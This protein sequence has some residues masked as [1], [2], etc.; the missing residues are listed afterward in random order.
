MNYESC[1]RI[2][3]RVRPEVTFIVAKM[4]FGRR[5]EL[6]RRI[7]D[8]TV[9]SDFLAAGETPKE[10]LELALLSADVDRVYVSWG[11]QELVGLEI[12]GVAATPDILASAGPEELFRE[13]AALIKVECGLS[14]EERKN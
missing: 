12:D 8:L 4:S 1:K 11:L 6:M 14:E 3:S 5:M 13:A 7:R 2:E 9:K 10:K